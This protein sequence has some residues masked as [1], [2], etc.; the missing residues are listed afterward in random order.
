MINHGVST[1]VQV[2]AKSTVG[3]VGQ[4][5]CTVLG[6]MAGSWLADKFMEWLEYI[7]AEDPMEG[8]R[9]ASEELGV[10][11]DAHRRDIKRAYARCH[12]DKG[13]GLSS[14]EFNQKTVAFSD[15]QGD[16]QN[17]YLGR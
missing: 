2:A 3:P 8:Y 10:A 17:E 7:F 11:E 9:R 4:F 12:P 15:H 6:N 1:L 14:E 13:S 5:A 16:E